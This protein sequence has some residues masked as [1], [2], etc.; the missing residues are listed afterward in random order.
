MPKA[1]KPTSTAT[2]HSTA[3]PAFLLTRTACSGAG[4]R[5]SPLGDS[6]VAA[7]LFVVGCSTGNLHDFGFLAGP[8]H[9]A[10]PVEQ[11]INDIHVALHPVVHHLGLVVCVH[12]DK[13]RG[14]AM[15]HARRHLDV[16][17]CAVIEDTNRTEVLILAV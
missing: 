5:S 2:T 17:L 3:I 9:E 11:A 14:L 7:L 1:I 10:R 16:G 8:E 12:H 15:L 4:F 13:D 6:I